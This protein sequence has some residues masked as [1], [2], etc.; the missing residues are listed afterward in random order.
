MGTVS[1]N[2]FSVGMKRNVKDKFKR[3]K[4]SSE[5]S[6]VVGNTSTK[7]IDASELPTGLAWD[8]CL[9]HVMIFLSSNMKFTLSCVSHGWS[10]H[11]DSRGSQVSTEA[12]SDLLGK[13]YGQRLLLLRNA[14]TELIPVVDW[15]IRPKRYW[16]Q[17]CDFLIGH[18]HSHVPRG[19]Q[20]STSMALA[21]TSDFM[22]CVQTVELPDNVSQEDVDRLSADS[23]LLA[24]TAMMISIKIEVKLSFQRVS[25]HQKCHCN[26]LCYFAFIGRFILRRGFNTISERSAQCSS[27]YIIS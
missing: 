11:F 2:W 5:N 23:Y 12:I 19:S 14:G 21:L 6:S 4:T 27:H 26:Q 3:P 16:T 1:S 10:Q 20:T 7:S 22:M 15:E 9:T 13:E 25:F 24:F 17:A 18:L 8:E